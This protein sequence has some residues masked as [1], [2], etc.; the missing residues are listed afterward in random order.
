[1]IPRGS[2]MSD[3]KWVGQVYK[4][5]TWIWIWY[6]F[7]KKVKWVIVSNSLGRASDPRLID[8]ISSMIG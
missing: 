4:V 1:M 2:V 8:S 6:C 7:D 5:R 3:S